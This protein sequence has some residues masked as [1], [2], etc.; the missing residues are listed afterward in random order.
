M[1]TV[2]AAFLE[3][4]FGVLWQIVAPSGLE[5]CARCLETYRRAMSVLAQVTARVEPAG[6]LPSMICR[7]R[8]ARPL[9]NR[10]DANGGK[11]EVPACRL[12]IDTSAGEGGHA[13]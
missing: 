12:M 10:A 1:R 6:P 7:C 13:P 8:D 9:G 11:V 2:I 5:R 3:I 4:S